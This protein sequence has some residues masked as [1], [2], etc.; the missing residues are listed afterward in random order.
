MKVFEPN[1]EAKARDSSV[2]G[3]CVFAIA[4]AITLVKTSSSN[5]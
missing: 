1:I 5:V 2:E 3:D 4:Q